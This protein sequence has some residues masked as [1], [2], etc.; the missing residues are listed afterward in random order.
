VVQRARVAGAEGR[1]AR[2]ELRGMLGSQTME[3]F[4]DLYKDFSFH[5][6]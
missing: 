4:I 3:V 1:L 6:E 5:F 2:D